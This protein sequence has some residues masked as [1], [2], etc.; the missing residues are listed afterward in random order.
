MIKV[1]LMQEGNKMRKNILI[2]GLIIS[3]ISM[4]FF[5]SQGVDA[6][7]EGQGVWLFDETGQTVSDSSANKNDGRL[8]DLSGD[9][10]WDIRE[11]NGKSGNCLVLNNTTPGT[12]DQFVIVPNSTSLNIT[13]NAISLEAWV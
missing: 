13:G 8:E 9:I 12:A 4:M 1:I 7:V 6:G 11:P 2:T 3:G 10:T 5:F